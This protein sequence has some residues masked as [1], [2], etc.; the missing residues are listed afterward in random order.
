MSEA[1]YGYC[2]RCGASGVSRERRPNGNDKCANGHTYPSKDAKAAAPLGDETE[3]QSFERWCIEE[4]YR[5][6]TG[7]HM[8]VGDLPAWVFVSHIEQLTAERDALQQRAERDAVLMTNMERNIAQQSVA[9]D[10]LTAT[11]IL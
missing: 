6:N 9:L 4:L 10:A 7:L 1:T 8:V 11:R 5:R 2:S 3:L